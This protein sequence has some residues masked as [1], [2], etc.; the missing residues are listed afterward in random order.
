MDFNLIKK[1]KNIE[2]IYYYKKILNNQ[3]LSY[4]KNIKKTVKNII[5]K[6]SSQ[7]IYE[8]IESSCCS[9]DLIGYI[10][11]YFYIETE[12]DYPVKK[13][14]DE[15]NKLFNYRNYFIKI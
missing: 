4:A 15:S 9:E 11:Y 13:D 8:K 1:L 2:D 14:I 3:L 12:S 7:N 6:S 10:N 5:G